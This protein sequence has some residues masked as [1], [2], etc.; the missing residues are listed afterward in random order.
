[1]FK[2]LDKITVNDPDFQI[3]KHLHRD[4]CPICLAGSIGMK[5]TRDFHTNPNFH[6]RDLAVVFKMTEEEVMDHINCHELV[7]SIESDVNGDLRKRISSPDFY[8]DELGTLYTAMRDCFEWVNRNRGED[9]SYDSIAIDQLTKL[10]D[11]VLKTITKMA[12]LQGRLK[13]PGDAQQKVLKVEGNFN[14]IMDIISGGGL[15]PECEKQIMSR[16]ERVE[17]LIQ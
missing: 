12:E 1:M 9:G 11:S 2:D 3:R 14:L 8:L 4:E 17:H 13:V 15:C 16:L 6:A 5:Y 7:V 10:N